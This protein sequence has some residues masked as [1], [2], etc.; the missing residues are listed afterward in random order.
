ML[1]PDKR[2]WSSTDLSDVDPPFYHAQ[3]GRPK[4]KRVRAQGEPHVESRASKRVAVK[5]SNCHT[6][7]PNVKGCGVP[8]RVD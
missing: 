7:G 4:K 1:V 8:L 6:Y 5:C 2:Q 3:P